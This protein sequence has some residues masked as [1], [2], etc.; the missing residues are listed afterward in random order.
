[1][2]EVDDQLIV[3]LLVLVVL[4]DELD[5]LASLRLLTE[6]PNQSEDISTSEASAFQRI[7]IKRSLWVLYLLPFE[8]IRSQA[9][10]IIV[11]S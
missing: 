5:Y 11:D 8:A 2:H 3:D 9:D 10:F 6:Q 7:S 1:M 4:F